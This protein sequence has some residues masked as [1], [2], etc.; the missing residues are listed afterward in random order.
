VIRVIGADIL[1]IGRR[2]IWLIIMVLLALAD[3]TFDE[4]LPKNEESGESSIE[5]CAGDFSVSIAYPTDN[6]E[7]VRIDK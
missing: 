1:V 5:V 4:G 3:W 6:S 2:G 7:W